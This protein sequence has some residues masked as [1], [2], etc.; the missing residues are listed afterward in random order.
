MAPANNCILGCTEKTD[1]V[2][3]CYP[4]FFWGSHHME[5]E[6]NRFGCKRE[7][8][9]NTPPEPGLQ[10]LYVWHSSHCWTLTQ[11]SFCSCSI[12]DD[13]LVVVWSGLASFLARTDWIFHRL[14]LV[15]GVSVS[16]LFTGHW[17]VAPS[18]TAVR[19]PECRCPV[20]LPDTDPLHYLDRLSGVCRPNFLCLKT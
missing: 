5:Q 13:H 17:P 9:T 15:S 20:F 8:D 7:M 10:T 16:G 19:C 18:V 14:R 6:N 12:G 11:L 3:K 4:N 2:W 1:Q